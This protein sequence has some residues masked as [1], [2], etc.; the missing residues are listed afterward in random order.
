MYHLTYLGPGLSFYFTKQRL[1]GNV[2]LAF[3]SPFTCPWFTY[4]PATWAFFL[5]Y[6]QTKLVFTSGPWYFLCCFLFLGFC[7]LGLQKRVVR[8]HSCSAHTWPPHI[9]HSKLA[10]SPSS[11]L[12]ITSP[13]FFSLSKINLLS[14]W[15]THLL[16][17]FTGK[18]CP[19]R[20]LL[21]PRCLEQ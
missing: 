16:T 17:V 1:G 19:P 18:E 2:P 5:L 6:E 9:T 14:S 13:Y 20:T 4:A 10:S 11:P 8:W 15:I 3:S 7:A 21:C 12:S